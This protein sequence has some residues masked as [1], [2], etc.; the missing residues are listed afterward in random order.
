MSGLKEAKY[1]FYKSDLSNVHIDTF[2]F[3]TLLEDV[4]GIFSGTNINSV[5]TMFQYNKNLR[6]AS[7]SFEATKIT[8]TPDRLFADMP[9]L[10]M[11][12]GAFRDCAG[13]G[14][15]T[16]SIFAGSP[17]ILDA[18][19]TF[20]GCTIL[21]K[22]PVVIFNEFRRCLHIDGIFEGCEMVEKL[23]PILMDNF[24]SVETAS[25]IFKDCIR[26]PIIPDNFLHSLV[27]CTTL[28]NAFSGIGA[29]GHVGNTILPENNALE[30]ATEM[31]KGQFNLTILPSDIFKFSP[32]L[33]YTIGTFEG[34]TG[35][36]ELPKDIIKV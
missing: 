10:Q 14:T 21:R 35:L 1:L 34:L 16:D 36:E 12:V 19:E 33:K 29:L 3:N 20:K 8:K 22:I 4:E 31:F 13:L 2:R 23:E 27:N 32:K 26:I 28:A 7:Y 30:D 18:S 9:N 6:I 24:V 17:N 11:V 25:R 5:P 15:I